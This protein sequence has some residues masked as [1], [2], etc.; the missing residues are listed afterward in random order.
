MR[1]QHQTCSSPVLH[2]IM[3]EEVRGQVGQMAGHTLKSGGIWAPKPNAGNILSLKAGRGTK[4]SYRWKWGGEFV[5][6]TKKHLRGTFLFRRLTWRKY[7]F[8]LD[9]V[10]CAQQHACDML[11]M[12]NR[13]LSGVKTFQAL[14]KQD[15]IIYVL[16]QISIFYCKRSY[17][18]V[19]QIPKRN[20][21][22]L[23]TKPCDWLL[24]GPTCRSPGRSPPQPPVLSG[25]HWAGM[26][27]YSAASSCFEGHRLKLWSLWQPAGNRCF[28]NPKPG[29]RSTKQIN[30]QY[31]SVCSIVQ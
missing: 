5:T 7:L 26:G 12:V 25:T 14:N 8:Q 6:N 10:L 20:P 18:Q 11:L 21:L 22:S 4:T 29:N 27:G 9:K 13:T 1:A 15:L 23:R 31:C 17:F 3:G 30:Q 19:D 16:S 2:C 28:Q 24:F